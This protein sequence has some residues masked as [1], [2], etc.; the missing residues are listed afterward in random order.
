MLHMSFFPVGN[1]SSLTTFT[2]GQ[3]TRETT[4]ATG[5]YNSH[6]HRFPSPF[7]FI[8]LLPPRYKEL[9]SKLV[10]S[11]FRA[12]ASQSC[13]SNAESSVRQAEREGRRLWGPLLEQ[14]SPMKL[15]HFA[16]M[17]RGPVVISQQ[18]QN[19]GLINRPLELSLM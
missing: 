5:L 14:V 8:S 16:S 2:A 1:G 9:C 3:A 18:R 11:R 15:L 12:V 6:G 10:I 13:L 4:A 19:F 17:G 7:P